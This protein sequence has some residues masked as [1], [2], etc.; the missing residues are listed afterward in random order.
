VSSS[1]SKKHRGHPGH[2]SISGIWW[3]PVGGHYLADV[4]VSGAT[5]GRPIF[6]STCSPDGGG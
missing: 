1:R 4:S 3:H 5:A 6:F 2:L